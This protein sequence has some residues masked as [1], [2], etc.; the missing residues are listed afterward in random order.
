MPARAMM[1]EGVT[2]RRT[3]PPNCASLGILPHLQNRAVRRMRFCCA[4]VG[5]G[6]TN[7][8]P[9][10]FSI[11]S[12]HARRAWRRDQKLAQFRNVVVRSRTGSLTFGQI[13]NGSKAPFGPCAD[14][15]L[16]T[17]KSR[18]F[19][20]PPACLKGAN[21]RHWCH[22]ADCRPQNPTP[23]VLRPP[24]EVD[25]DDVGH[26]LHALRPIGRHDEGGRC[27]RYPIP[28]GGAKVNHGRY[29]LFQMARWR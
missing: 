8:N 28:S 19:Q 20:R 27:A 15:F 22:V 26:R 17:S 6:H 23:I 11:N 29:V 3:S 18:H 1:I 21:E 9:R 25:I 5:G 16:S 14:H 13:R 24:V 7:A 4:C 12:C 2:R 10:C